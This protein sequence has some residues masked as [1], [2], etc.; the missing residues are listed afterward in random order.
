MD[1]KCERRQE[2]R[3]GEAIGASIWWDC[4]LLRSTGEGE[5]S[6]D[7]DSFY[8][9]YHQIKKLGLKPNSKKIK[10]GGW[11]PYENHLYL[12]FMLRNYQDFETERGRRRNKVFYRLS[13][14]LRRR[15]PDQCRSHHQKL[16]MKHGDNLP[17]IVREIQQKIQAA[18]IE[19]LERMRQRHSLSSLEMKGCVNVEEG[20][21]FRM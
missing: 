10:N 14:I 3:G 5:V 6:S 16:Q 21:W 7:S 20:G 9:E 2:G 1:A 17:A 13:K 8:P 15:T 4:K 12:R 11:S 18:A 19:Q